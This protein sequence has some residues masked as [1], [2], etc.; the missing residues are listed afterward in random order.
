MGNAA[1]SLRI[2][3]SQLGYSESPAGS[4]MTKFGAWYG[5]NGN[6]W[7]DMFQSWVADQAGNGAIVGK[8]A[9][10]PS[11][12]S[13]F[14]SRGQWHTGRD[15][16]VGDLVFFNFGSGRIHHVGIVEQVRSD[17]IVTIEGNT[18]GGNNANGGQVQR[19]FRSWNVGIV[20]YGRPAYTDTVPPLSS[21]EQLYIWIKSGV[22]ARKLPFL[23]PG[24]TGESVKKVQQLLGLPQT[25]TYGPA[26]T[27]RVKAFQ[28]ICKI[29]HK[30]RD[31]RMNFK[32]W[33]QLLYFTF[34]KGRVRA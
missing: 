18:S 16:K 22:L 4:N 1:A 33:R 11:H 10:T 30:G 31:G 20:G 23:K 7:C 24:D 17:G 25:G 34:T 15:V 13:W 5:M 29:P 28:A 9:Y 12:A 26:V 8:F 14:Q 3:Q 6:A 32:T 21:V 27:E 2:A 19:R